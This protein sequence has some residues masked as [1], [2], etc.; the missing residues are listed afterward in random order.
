LGDA[1]AGREPEPAV[2]NGSCTV[3]RLSTVALP[4]AHSV[5][6]HTSDCHLPQLPSAH[7]SNPT[8]D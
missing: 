6:V 7:L 4:P 2:A 1:S 3:T 5:T 8:A